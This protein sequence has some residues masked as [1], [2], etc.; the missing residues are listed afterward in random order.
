MSRLP[1]VRYF[2]FKQM[3]NKMK[4][5][6]LHPGLIVNIFGN[7][8]IDYSSSQKKM[9]KINLHKFYYIVF[10]NNT[11]GPQ[12]T[13]INSSS[14]P[15]QGNIE[16]IENWCKSEASRFQIFLLP[17]FLQCDFWKLVKKAVEKSSFCVFEKID[18]QPNF[19]Y[20]QQPNRQR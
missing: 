18:H 19:E 10:E 13:F 20:A 11:M 1:D 9:F 17:Q 2:V 12:S 6:C 4:V 8:L 15:K 14:C 5:K 3:P 16:P 7:I